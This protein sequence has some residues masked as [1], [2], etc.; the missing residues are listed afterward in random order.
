M[1][2][3]LK[4]LFLPE[5]LAFELKPKEAVELDEDRRR[6]LLQHYENAVVYKPTI[7][8]ARE[9]AESQ[10]VCR[11]RFRR[12][13]KS[14]KLRRNG[15][16]RFERGPLPR[17]L[18]LDKE[19]PRVFIKGDKAYLFVPVRHVRTGHVRGWFARVFSL[20]LLRPRLKVFEMPVPVF[21]KHFK[22]DEPAPK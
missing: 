22:L 16:L 14:F 20:A 3:R 12:W 18:V 13:I 21:N 1:F 9:T 11:H 6:D 15:R 5:K 10:L 2:V 8:D 4:T 7:N 19:N 17:Y